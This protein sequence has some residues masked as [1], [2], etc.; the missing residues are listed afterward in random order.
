MQPRK[1]Y[2]LLCVS[3]EQQNNYLKDFYLLVLEK[4]QHAMGGGLK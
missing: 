1:I 3:T 4:G 2:S